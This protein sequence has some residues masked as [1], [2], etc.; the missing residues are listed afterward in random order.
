MGQVGTSRWRS[1][2]VGTVNASSEESNLLLEIIF[3]DP[4]AS[5]AS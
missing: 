3:S 1:L 5:V 4:V 2:G